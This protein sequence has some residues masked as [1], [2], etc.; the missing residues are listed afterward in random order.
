MRVKTLLNRVEPFK[1]FVIDRVWVE[2][3]G[4]TEVLMVQLRER[5]NGRG[6]CPK[7]M[8]PCAGYDRLEERCWEYVPVWGITTLL[9]Y[10]P[11]RVECPEHG[12]VR[13]WLPW[14]EGKGWLARSYMCFLAK[15]AKRLSITEVAEV[16]HTSW[17]KVFRSVEWAVEVGLALR[18]VQDV[19]AI[20]VDEI[21]RRKGHRY[22]TVV[23]QIDEA[24]RRLLWVGRERT[25]E[26]LRSFFEEFGSEWTSRLK[27]I[28]SDMWQPYLDVIAKVAQT[29][30]NVL[31][32]YH[33]VARMS[34]AI[35]KVRAQE[36]K[37]L[38]QQGKDPVLKG[39]RWLFLKRKDN[40]SDEE[41]ST[42]KELVGLNLKTVRACLLKEEFDLK[43]WG[44]KRAWAAGRFLD[45][46]CTK[47][48]RSK[49]EPMKDIAMSLRS[50]RELILNW[51]KAR[52]AAVSLGAVEGFNNKAQL[53]KR[54]SYGFRTFR[55][56]RVMLYHGL[57][58]LPE[59]E[60][61]HSF[62]C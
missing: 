54:R 24:R 52:E 17:K 12:V 6:L 62:C 49:I 40:R 21:Q 22:L 47:V 51:F 26:C 31:D 50:H 28:C 25:Q 59:P 38:K 27:F 43:F 58:D 14:S 35:D 16:F 9:A 55:V 15:W 61:E 5:A 30:K 13:E 45:Q 57:A 1:P 53:I 36:A 4:E 44:Y 41:R 23:Y 42:L 2:G 19:T 34:K 29:A 20:G 37:A 3:E 39:T 8:E 32:R 11:R 60:L 46:W 7:C 33:L 56:A 10:A 48:M 18:D